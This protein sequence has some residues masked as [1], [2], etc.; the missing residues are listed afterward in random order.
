MRSTKALKQG[1]K[2]LSKHIHIPLNPLK[3]VVRFR[4][5]FQH[6]QGFKTFFQVRFAY[7]KAIYQAHTPPT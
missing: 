4:K 6:Q 5:V 7:V 3:I 2:A 1:L